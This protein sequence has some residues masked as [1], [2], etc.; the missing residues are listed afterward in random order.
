MKPARGPIL[1]FT[2]GSSRWQ[3]RH[4]FSWAIFRETSSPLHCLRVRGWPWQERHVG[5]P[6]ACASSARP[7]EEAAN[8]AATSRWQEPHDS[9]G[10]SVRYRNLSDRT[11]T[12][13]CVP[14]HCLQEGSAPAVRPEWKGCFSGAS[15]WHPSQATGSI[16][17]LW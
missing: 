1:D 8:G 13:S 7:C 17:F 15:E 6:L 12:T 5:A 2:S 16:F 3:E 14:W 10:R 9:T 11:E 4:I